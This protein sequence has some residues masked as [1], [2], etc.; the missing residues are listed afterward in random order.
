MLLTLID[1]T[2]LDARGQGNSIRPTRSA[3]WGINEGYKVTVEN[4][5]E[6]HQQLPW[7]MLEWIYFTMLGH[8]KNLIGFSK[9]R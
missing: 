7:N 6:N 1:P 5:M 3:S 8:K 4:Q 9:S 2:Q